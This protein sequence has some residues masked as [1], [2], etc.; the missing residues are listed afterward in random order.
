MPCPGSPAPAACDRKLLLQSFPKCRDDLL[1]RVSG[2]HQ[3]CGVVQPVD[4]DALVEADAVAAIRAGTRSI[5]ARGT[6]TSSREALSCPRTRSPSQANADR[7][8]KAGSGSLRAAERRAVR[9][10]PG[11]APARGVVTPHRDSSAH[12]R[13]ACPRPRWRARLQ[14]QNLQ[15]RPTA[16]Y[17]LFVRFPL[18][19]PAFLFTRR[20]L[21][22]VPVSVST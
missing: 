21:R 6:T 1:P 3:I 8:G 14:P 15:L 12:A 2:E 7:A 5:P 4:M 16:C 19:F 9:S 11:T 13:P 20:A 17:A 10:R 22:A 18:P